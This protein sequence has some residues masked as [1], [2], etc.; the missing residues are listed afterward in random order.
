[1]SLKLVKPPSS[2]TSS[3]RIQLTPTLSKIFEQI[4]VRHLNIHLQDTNL[5]PIH[6][7]EF[8]PDRSSHD[9]L[10]R[11]SNH[12]TNHFKPSCLVL[13]DF[14][15][16]FDKVWHHGLIWN[17]LSFHLPE[18]CI[19]YIYNFFT[20]SFAYIANNNLSSFSVFLQTTLLV[21]GRYSLSCNRMH[22]A[23]IDLFIR[24]ALNGNL[25]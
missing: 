16:A 14:D 2:V 4:I 5:L 7:S 9:P 23:A 18:A 10:L 12:I 19:K 8:R 6:Q 11:R 1:M 15:K 13:L 22:N 20:K 3:T 24:C 17:L 25:L 21:S